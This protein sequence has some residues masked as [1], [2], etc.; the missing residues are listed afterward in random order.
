MR[1]AL[2][3]GLGDIATIQT[4]S[5]CE[6]PFDPI[7]EKRMRKRPL[8]LA[9]SFFL[10]GIRYAAEKDIWIL[11]LL[12][13]LVFYLIFP[14]IKVFGWNQIGCKKV[15]LSVVMGIILFTAGMV[16]MEQKMEFQESYLSQITEGK[17]TT[18]L[19]KISKIEKN[20]FGYQIHVSDCYIFQN[21]KYI[22]CNDILVYTS[23][24]KVQVGE[25]H[26]ITGK[27]HM[28]SQACNEGN[29]DSALYYKSQGIDFF[30]DMQNF[31]YVAEQTNSI[32]KMSLRLKELLSEVY[33][34]CLNET[35]A[36]VIKGMVLGDKSALE[37]EIKQLFTTAGIS[38]MLAISGLHVSVIGRG[39][40][41]FLRKIGCGFFVS[42][43]VA[44]SVLLFYGIMTGNSISARRAIGMLFISMTGQVFGR[45]YDM[46]NALGAMCLFLLWKNPFLIEYS[47][48][49]FFVTAL[50]GVGFVGEV[51]TIEISED[52][53]N[54][55]V[56][57]IHK[58]VTN[59]NRESLFYKEHTKNS[60]TNIKKK[61][62]RI[63]GI[64]ILHRFQN[65]LWMS[66]GVTL[67]TL[68][69]VAYCYFEVPILSSF[70][71]CILIPLMTPLF[72]CAL[73]GGIAGIFYMPLANILL[74]P[75]RWIL[76]LYEWVCR[77]NEKLSFFTVITGKPSIERI[78]FYYIVLMGG[79][80][81]LKYCQ[82]LLLQKEEYKAVQ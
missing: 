5:E 54:G 44:G 8:L 12:P 47:G 66:I 9:A 14:K 17:K 6:Y 74:Y 4:S 79:L 81:W 57:C 76:G 67:M 43:I 28:F 39:L 26:K 32:V 68:P 20:S 27:L 45:S 25:I 50:F 1:E 29:F 82:T 70:I 31:E 51:F 60:D 63:F 11:V 7:G 62:R 46:L 24:P 55:K 30:I 59:V 58:K 61:N 64:R 41:H 72:F 49:W 34:T 35:Y 10:A 40:Y 77:W 21:S 56:T 69:V 65:A 73:F 13:F 37:E 16:H 15:F 78:M 22:P 33:D 36:G 48:F 80:I 18:I 75:C 52:K 38:H 23:K 53:T 3:G 19:G 42:G 71:N 2:S